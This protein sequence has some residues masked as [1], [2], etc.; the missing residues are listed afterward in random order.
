M[1]QLSHLENLSNFFSIQLNLKLTI[2]NSS[3]QYYQSYAQK[4]FLDLITHPIRNLC[5]ETSRFQTNFSPSQS[6]LSSKS[7]LSLFNP[8][9]PRTSSPRSSCPSVIFILFDERSCFCSGRGWKGVVS[10]SVKK[11]IYICIV[12]RSI[13][14]RAQKS[15]YI[16]IYFLQVCFIGPW[17]MSVQ[18]GTMLNPINF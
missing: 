17:I 18:R 14:I 3:I 5:E 1:F 15:P 2:N 16:Y 9:D 7:S 4:F 12:S 6:F 13:E 10:N 8:F 11:N